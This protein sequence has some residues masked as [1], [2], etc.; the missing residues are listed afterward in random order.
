MGSPGGVGG[1][2]GRLCR[3]GTYNKL[4]V[5][6]KAARKDLG[7]DVQLG[8]HNQF[9][10]ISEQTDIVSRLMQVCLCGCDVEECPDECVCVW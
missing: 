4:M 8:F 10:I 9:N 6:S 2:R 5:H 1:E 3:G 7:D